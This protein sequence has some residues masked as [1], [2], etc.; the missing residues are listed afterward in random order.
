MNALEGSF[1]ER[2][3]RSL[4]AGCDVVLHCSGKAAEMKEVAAACGAMSAQAMVRFS[5]GLERRQ[6]WHPASDNQ[7]RLDELGSLLAGA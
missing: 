4:A 6:D 1:G 2:S 7:E 3:S 5:R